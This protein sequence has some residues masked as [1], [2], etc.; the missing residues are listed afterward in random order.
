[1]VTAVFIS[2]DFSQIK[3]IVAKPLNSDLSDA[4]KKKILT[5][6][7]NILKTVSDCINKYLNPSKTQFLCSKRRLYRAKVNWS[8]YEH[9]RYKCR[10][11][12]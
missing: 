9:A 5:Y 2:V 1:M 10:C 4:K 8:S 12:R 7:Y 6:R 11:L 3:A